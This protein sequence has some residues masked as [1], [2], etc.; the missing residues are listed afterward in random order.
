VVE[1]DIP[2]GNSFGEEA[3]KTL[4]QWL[5]HLEKWINLAADNLQ[6]LAAELVNV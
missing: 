6:S 3:A 4:A 5:P 1:L 2:H